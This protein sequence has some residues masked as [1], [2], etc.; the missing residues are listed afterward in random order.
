MDGSEMHM[1]GDMWHSFGMHQ[2]WS[3]IITILVISFIIWAVKAF[4]NKNNNKKEK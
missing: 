3:W 1:T 4:L 2:W